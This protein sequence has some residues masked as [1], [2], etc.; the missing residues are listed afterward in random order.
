MDFL[1]SF[2]VNGG[3]RQQILSLFAAEIDM[4]KTGL[5][6]HIAGQSISVLNISVAC[7][8]NLIQFAVTVYQRGLYI[9]KS[10]AFLLRVNVA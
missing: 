1:I 5:E 7:G 8:L 6:I 4:L 9:D 2:Q 3:Y 10:T